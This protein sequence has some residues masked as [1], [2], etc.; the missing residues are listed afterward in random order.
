MTPEKIKKLE[1]LKNKAK[2][3]PANTYSVIWRPEVGDVLAGEIVRRQKFK[4]QQYGEQVALILDTE[5]GEISVVLN[6]FLMEELRNQKAER[7]NLVA[8]V[9]HGKRQNKH[10][11]TYNHYAMFVDHDFN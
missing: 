2:E 6:K 7:G 10:N 3:A 1:E 11:G 5:K 9:Y 8:I 4:H